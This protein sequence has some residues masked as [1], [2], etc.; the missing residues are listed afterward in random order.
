[1]RGKP[2]REWRTDM[3]NTETPGFLY[4]ALAFVMILVMDL[5]QAVQDLVAP[6]G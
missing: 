2:Y 1:M 5:L 4:I 6:E 3:H